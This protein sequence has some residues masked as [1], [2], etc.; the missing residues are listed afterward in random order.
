MAPDL[1]RLRFYRWLAWS[2]E[3]DLDKVVDPYLYPRLTFN[4]YPYLYPYSLTILIL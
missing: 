4:Y 2:K 3:V 1:I